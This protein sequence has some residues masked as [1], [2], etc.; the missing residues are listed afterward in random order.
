MAI[1]NSYVT[2]Y[3]SVPTT[4]LWVLG[5]R[6]PEP[7]QIQSITVLCFSQERFFA[8]V[9]RVFHGRFCS[10][11]QQSC[12][13]SPPSRKRVAFCNWGFKRS[14]RWFQ[15]TKSSIHG[16]DDWFNQQWYVDSFVGDAPRK[17]LDGAASRLQ[18]ISFHNVVRGTGNL[19][20][21]KHR[22]FWS[23]L[24]MNHSSIG[25]WEYCGSYICQLLGTLL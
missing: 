19:A 8:V 3:Q 21:V 16:K 22:F 20:V 4:V 15:S 17:D 18:Q 24:R 14:A 12:P 23:F 7:P 2:N 5:M 6:D 13:S 11:Y 10:C 9:C 1:F 25:S